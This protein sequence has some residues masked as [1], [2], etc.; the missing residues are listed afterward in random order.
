MPE[1]PEVEVSRQGIEPGLVGQTISDIVVRTAKLRWAV[2][3]AIH[4]THGH[5]IRSVTRRAKYLFIN[6]DAGSVILH[7]GMTGFLRV[8]AQSTA[9]KKHDHLDINLSNGQCLRFNDARK[10]GA[11]LWQGIDDEPHVLLSALGPEPLTDDFT[12]DHLHARAQ[13]RTCTVKQFVMDNK[14]VVGVGNIYA[15][16]ALFLAKIAPKRAAGKI[17][18][19]RYRVLTG[20]IKEVLA[21]AIVQGGTTLKDFSQVDGNPGYFSLH[22]NVYGRAGEACRICE[23]EI[24]SMMIGQRNTFWC[25][26]CQR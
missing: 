19:K 12:Q 13:G 23:T 1:L 20:Y 11:C 6:T 22:L 17:S 26:S 25:P 7:L 3:E 16:E 5:I 9:L 18:A 10:F 21:A 2:P 14:N 24:K 8:F 4:Q 15:N